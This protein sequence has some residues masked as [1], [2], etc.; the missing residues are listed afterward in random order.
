MALEESQTVKLSLRLDARIHAAIQQ[1]GRAL[2]REIDEHIQ[3]ILTEY[4]IQQKLLDD[5]TEKELKM[6][7][8]LVQRAVETAR[9]I[10]R[11]GGFTPDITRNTFHTCMEDKQ[12]AADYEAYVKDN[13][14]KHGN[15]R[16]GPI[17]K[18]I[19]LRIR[20]GI[21]GLVATS[22]GKPVKIAVDGEVI[23]SYTQMKWFDP[24]AVGPKPLT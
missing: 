22:D 17:N 23:Q 12:W 14:Y 20:A 24:D 19:G 4:A 1:E 21:G 6:K 13:P 9:R 3:R 16:K 15:P 11:E 8:S 10:C 5:A 2:G 7:W 18:E